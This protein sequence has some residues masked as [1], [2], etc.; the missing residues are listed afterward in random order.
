[1]MVRDFPGHIAWACTGKS[2]EGYLALIEYQAKTAG[3]PPA[4]L[5]V[6]AEACLCEDE[7]LSIASNRLDELADIR[8]V[9][10]SLP[11][12]GNVPFGSDI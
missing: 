2:E 4:C 1:M 5:R 11:S 9:S 10:L 12:N 6:A 3:T 8:Q 7:A